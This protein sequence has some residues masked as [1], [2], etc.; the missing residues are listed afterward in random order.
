MK[1]FN[2][3]NSEWRSPESERW[4]DALEGMEP[5]NVRAI[6]AGA[7]R[8][9]GSRACISVGS[10]MDITKG[11]AQEWL[12]WHDRIKRET[13]Y[14]FRWWQIAMTGWAAGAATVAALAGAV[15]WAWTILH[16]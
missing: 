6:L 13:E 5:D 10:V 8:D 2:Y 14:N 4:L 15:G 3:E 11:F 9:V 16:K 12:A 7:Y 1:R